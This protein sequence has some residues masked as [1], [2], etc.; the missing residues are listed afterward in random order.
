VRQSSGLSDPFD[1]IN[2]F[3]VYFV[4]SNIGTVVGEEGIILRTTDGG[5]SWVPQSNGQASG[6]L[7]VYFTDTTNGTVVGNDGVI[8]RTTDG[9]QNWI[10]QTIGTN[11]PA[12]IGLVYGGRHRHCC[13]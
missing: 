12:S 8:L 6:L 7:G 2:F 9:G 1:G 5:Q 11:E 10:P 4:N 3:G 13:R